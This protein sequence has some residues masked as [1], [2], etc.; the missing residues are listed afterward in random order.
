MDPPTVSLNPG[1]NF[2]VQVEVNNVKNLYTYEFRLSWNPSFL[3]VNSVT[4][5]PFLNS[6]GTYLT[7]FQDKIY[8]TP[9]SLGVSGY[10]YIA[11]SLLG[12]LATAA[13]SGNGT[14]ATIEFQ[15]NEWGNTSLHLC[16]TKLIDSLMV[17]ISHETE[18][19]YSTIIP[20]FPSFLV[21]PLFITTLLLAV[22]I[23]RRKHPKQN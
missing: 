15:T 2:A 8:N 6:E 12:E 16:A 1:E 23:S 5:G 3:E 4:E 17:E 9:D 20:E 7:Y 14:L 18:D 21:L 19:G 13:A 22:I 11:C 10:A